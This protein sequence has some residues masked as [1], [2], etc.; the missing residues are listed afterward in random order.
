VPDP[1]LGNWRKVDTKS[2]HAVNRDE[3]DRI[4][5]K[6]NASGIGSLSPQERQFLSNFVPPDDRT[7]S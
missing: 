5:D 2:I 3:V 4:L 7:P 6:I 1:A